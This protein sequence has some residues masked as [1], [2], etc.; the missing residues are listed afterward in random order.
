MQTVQNVDNQHKK[1]LLAYMNNNAASY[2]LMML[3]GFL[4]HPVP[5]LCEGEVTS[6]SVLRVAFN[7][8]FVTETDSYAEN[9]TSICII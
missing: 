4:W 8:S 5:V 3:I 9:V 6:Q 7:A 1:S 2:W